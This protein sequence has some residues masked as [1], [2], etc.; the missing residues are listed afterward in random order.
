MRSAIIVLA[1][2][3]SLPALADDF[4]SD[5]L[6]NTTQAQEIVK[7][8]ESPQARTP[9][10]RA[11]LD[12]RKE[13]AVEN[14]AR[15]ADKR[16]DNPDAQLAVGRSLATV[17]EA[18]RAIPY[19]ERGLKLAEASGDPKLLRTALLTGSEIYYKAGNYE[20]ARKRARSVLDGNPKDKDALALYMLVKDRGAGDSASPT[21]SPKTSGASGGA[22]AGDRSA[23]AA[24]DSP[25]QSQAAAPGVAMTSASSLEV[26]KQLALGRSRLELDP[27]EA[28]KYFDAAVAADEKDAAA[29]VQ[30][31]QA[32]LKAGDAAGALS[33]A[34]AAVGLAPTLGEAFAARAEAKRA[35][36]KREAEL[37]ADYE[38]AAKLDG[39]F[40]QAYKAVL[41]GGSGAHADGNAGAPAPD[42]TRSMRDL[43]MEKKGIAGLVAAAMAILALVAAFS[44]RRSGEDDS[45]PR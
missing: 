8:I 32:R 38:A 1:V 5:L 20:L 13:A 18:P 17:K 7:Q 28:L 34:D 14:I 24:T 33:D 36:G 37:L 11:D 12:R 31:S 15:I 22:S 23:S 41:L 6:E 3:V 25:S 35:L 27:K 42:G 29:R 4:D 45:L 21:D 10:E 26:Q 16:P 43:V 2:V 9:E 39:R 19:A 40:A 44:R 30:R